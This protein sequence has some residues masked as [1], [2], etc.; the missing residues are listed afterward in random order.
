MLYALCSPLF[1]HS[2]RDAR[3]M[4]KGGMMVEF[5]LALALAA[6]MLPF[7]L[8]TEVARIERA[9]NVRAARDMG[10]VRAALERYIDA[11][12]N[13]FGTN[14]GVI[15]V[16]IAAL[17]DYGLNPKEINNAEKFQL[18]VIKSTNNVGRAFLQGI[19]IMTDSDANALRTREI[20]T[21]AGV[22]AGF[23]EGGRTYGAYGTWSQNAAIWNAK[24]AD[25]SVV[26]MTS[27]ARS[28]NLYL[29]RTASGMDADATMGADL[30]LGN[31][32]I[33]DAR[34][35]AA[36]TANFAEF[37]NASTIRTSTVT[38]E[39]QP[40]LDGTMAFGNVTVNGAL[41]SDSKGLHADTLNLSGAARFNSVTAKDLKTGDLTLSG[42]SVT[43]AASDPHNPAIAI[44]SINQTLDMTGG[45]ITALS[46]NVGFTG[47]VTPQLSVSDRIEDATNAAYYWNVSGGDATLAD[48]SFPNLPTLMQS[49]VKKETSSPKTSAET[50]MA[51]IASNANATASDFLRALATIQSRVE[52][53][54]QQLNLE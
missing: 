34:T 23:A 24:F 46:V 18:R 28:S 19:V 15:R 41:S 36:D 26:D 39:N 31:Q 8:R 20:A 49:V 54:Y 12:K 6:A 50:I 7:L 38:F 21:L 22:S 37:L 25:N 5:L 16:S 53:E 43:S 42:L 35:V 51:P 48:V 3:R 11:N 32:G 27:P 30:S 4:Q 52:S 29:M 40:S 47:S 44:L 9:A 45:A 17:S 1:L 2:A 14:R 13:N 33:R 10:M